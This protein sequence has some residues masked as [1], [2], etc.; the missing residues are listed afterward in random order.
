M[1]DAP[2]PPRRTL[3]FETI[4]DALAEADRLV[5]AEREGRL[6]RAGNWSLG[7]TLGHLATWAEF[8]FNGYPPSIRPPAPI[9]WV[10]RLLKNRVLTKGMTP[11]VKLGRLPGGTLG[12]DDLPPDD[13]LHRFRAALQRL[14]ASAPTS[15]NP[16]FG[17]LTHQEWIQLNLRHAELHLGH[18]VPRE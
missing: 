2:K 10:L 12:L 3:R 16:V 17:P 14:K 7:Q 11:G 4:D 15:D 1:A 8:A 6:T 13:A 18:Q 5:A 9:R